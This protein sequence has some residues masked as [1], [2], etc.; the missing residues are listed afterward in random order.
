M[1]KREL[2]SPFLVQENRRGGRD[3]G[4]INKEIVYLCE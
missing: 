3:L 1:K 2:K 4:E